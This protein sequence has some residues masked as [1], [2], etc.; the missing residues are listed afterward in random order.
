MTSQQFFLRKK[1]GKEKSRKKILRPRSWS[2]KMA[3][4]FLRLRSKSMNW[5]SRR[6][7]LSNS[8]MKME[9]FPKKSYLLRC[10]NS[11]KVLTMSTSL[12]KGHSLMDLIVNTLMHKQS[13]LAGEPN[14][15]QNLNCYKL[16]DDAKVHSPHRTMLCV[17]SVFLKNAEIVKY[18]I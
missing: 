13:I 3:K 8:D 2:M 9:R 12:L 10:K 4:R 17:G 11:S 5:P 7:N 6:W 18:Y 14:N 15:A 16:R 1:N